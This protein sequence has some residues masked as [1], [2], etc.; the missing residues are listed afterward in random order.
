MTARLVAVFVF[1]LAAGPA[2]G[3]DEPAAK[4]WA[5]TV[6]SEKEIGK[7]PLTGTVPN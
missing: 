2:F 7:L 6:S 3:G 1:M 5:L 4:T